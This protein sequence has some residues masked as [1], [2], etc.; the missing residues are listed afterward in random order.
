MK[1]TK[2]VTVQVLTFVEDQ[3]AFKNISFMKNKL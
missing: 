3:R 1:L 2:I